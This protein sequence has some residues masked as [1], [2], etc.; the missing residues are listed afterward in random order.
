MNEDLKSDAFWRGLLFGA[1]GG[2]AG[3]TFIF[4]LTEWLVRR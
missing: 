1:V 3:V 2:I 4:L